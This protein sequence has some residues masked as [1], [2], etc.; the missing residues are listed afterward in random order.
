MGRFYDKQ[1]ARHN[2]TVARLKREVAARQESARRLIAAVERE[3]LVFNEAYRQLKLVV[4]QARKDLGLDFRSIDDERGGHSGRRY[5][6]LEDD[7]VPKLPKTFKLAHNGTRLLAGFYWSQTVQFWGRHPVTLNMTLLLHTTTFDERKDDDERE[8]PWEDDL[9]TTI[10]VQANVWYETMV[11]ERGN[12]IGNVTDALYFVLPTPALKAKP[13]ELLEVLAA[14]FAFMNLFYKEVGGD[15]QMRDAENWATPELTK[16]FIA[17]R[18]LAH[19][20]ILH[21]LEDEQLDSLE[22]VESGITREERREL[23]EELTRCP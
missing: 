15:P 5:D 22:V 9:R 12:R 17:L 13:S 4:D 14:G 7:H 16:R 23:A 8:D 18:N 19:D 1:V 6:L 21:E 20:E 2:E 11:D 10:T 3:V